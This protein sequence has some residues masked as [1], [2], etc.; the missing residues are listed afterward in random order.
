[1]SSRH[2]LIPKRLGDRAAFIF[3]VLTLAMVIHFELRTVLPVYHQMY[4]TWWCIHV[5]CTFFTA[6]N[7]FTNLFFMMVTDTTTG[8]ASLP[9]VLKPGWQ[10]CPFCQLNSPPR[11]FHCHICDTCILKR[12]HHCIFGGKCIGYKNYRYYIMMVI[13]LWIGAAYAN[14]YHF[15]FA[16]D[17]AGGFKMATF[18][19][20]F[21]PFIMLIFGYATGYQF[22]VL[23]IAGV[24]VFSFLLFSGLLYMQIRIITKGQVSYERKRG[25]KD[26]DLGLIENI[27]DVLGVRWY[28]AWI[29]PLIPSLLPGDGVVFRRRDEVI[30]IKRMW[31]LTWLLTLLF[32][33]QN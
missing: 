2:T 23:F 30:N 31:T 11:S 29:S 16:H 13:F 18:F 3:F 10:Y 25:I 17:V 15:E 22:Y 19:T 7:V 20:M 24:S 21:M 9:S 8:S 4:S 27:K 26:Y 5:C 1:M 28:V 32:A 6:T 14:I 33:I 12:D